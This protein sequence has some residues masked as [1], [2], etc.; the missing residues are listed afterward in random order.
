MPNQTKTKHSI[1]QTK[2]ES[3]KRPPHKDMTEI[4]YQNKDITSKFLAENFQGKTF[5][6]YGLELPEIKRVLPTNIPVV[7]ANELRLDNLFELADGTTAL[8]DYESEYDPK[9]KI[10]Y[11]NYLTGIANRFLQENMDC[12]VIRMIVIYTGNIKRGQISDKYDIGALTLTIETAFLSELDSE[13]IRAQLEEKVKASQPLTDEELM[14][15]IILPLSYQQKE[16]QQKMLPEI[17]ELAVKIQDRK[18]QIFILA[19]ILVF[20]DKIIDREMANRIRRKIE[21]TQVAQ[22]F[23]EEKRQALERAAQTYNEE[24]RRADQTYNEEKRQLLEQ[25]EAERRQIVIRMIKKNYSIEEISSLISNYSQEEI[26]LLRKE[27]D[28][29]SF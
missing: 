20:T 11:L 17:V 12:P 13:E 18:Q 28:A 21:L 29:D 8:V 22:I 27:I 10:K 3:G 25:A 19:G 6:V 4:A 2:S 26:E 14:K 5:R 15:F 7:K 23:E 24:K 1:Q 9:D 16:E